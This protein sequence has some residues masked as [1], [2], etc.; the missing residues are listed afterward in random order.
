[1]TLVDFVDG[2]GIELDF[3]DVE[4]ELHSR[5][6]ADAVTGMA[7]LIEY[8]RGMTRRLAGTAFAGWEIIQHYVGTLP[9]T[10]TLDAL[11][12]EF[13]LQYA[14]GTSETDSGDDGA[15]IIIGRSQAGNENESLR[16]NGGWDACSETE[17]V[18][19]SLATPAWMC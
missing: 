4:A 14:A 16:G 6:A 19:T 7:D 17:A 12:E 2:G 13:G 5:V 18:T 9:H 11:Y 3:T 10:P 1:M 8:T 15:N